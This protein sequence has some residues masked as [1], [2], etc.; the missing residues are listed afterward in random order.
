MGSPEE[1]ANRFIREVWGL[2]V[3]AYLVVGLRYFSR[4]HT[5]GWKKLAWD[6][7]LMFLAIVS[8]P[9]GYHSDRD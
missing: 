5:L 6:D 8:R 7:A 3:A 2:Q 9:I 4:I 1:E